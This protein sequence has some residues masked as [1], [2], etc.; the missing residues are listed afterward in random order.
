[1]AAA[2]GSVA[3]QLYAGRHSPERL[4]LLLIAGWVLAPFLV[5]LFMNLLAKRSTPVTRK[6]LHYVMLVVSAASLTVYAIAVVRPLA[7]KPPAFLFVAVPPASL[8]LAAITWATT[9]LAFRQRHRRG[10]N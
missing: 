9:W 4:V 6:A 3:L 1:M 2:V 10:A 5:L 7:S 8:G